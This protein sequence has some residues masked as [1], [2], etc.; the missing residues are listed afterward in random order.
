MTKKRLLPNPTKE[1]DRIFH[2]FGL[3]EFCSV[4]SDVF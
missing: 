3:E 2:S 1:A 4:P